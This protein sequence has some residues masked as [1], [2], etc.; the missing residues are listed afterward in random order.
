MSVG[1]AIKDLPILRKL[2]KTRSKMKRKKILESCPL[3]VFDTISDISDNILKGN[4][5]LSAKQYKKL[6]PY[7]KI[8]RK[9]GKK[10]SSKNKKQ[11]VIQNGGALPALLLPAVT[12][13]A[14]IISRK[15]IK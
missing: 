4:I 13:L 10:T 9:L 7:K 2:T 14:D 12:I 1:K 6:K 15:L 8:V 11:I 3:H 5:S